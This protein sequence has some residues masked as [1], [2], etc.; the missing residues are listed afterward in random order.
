M[1]KQDTC[2]Y[3]YLWT[4]A[5]HNYEVGRATYNRAKYLLECKKMMQ[6]WAD[7]LD[8]VLASADKVVRGTF[9]KDKEKNNKTK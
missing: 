1:L 3:H 5:Q 4:K 7:Y 2:S 8:G 6:E 9:G